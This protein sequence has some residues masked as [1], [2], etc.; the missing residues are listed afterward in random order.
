MAKMPT[1]FIPH[2]GG[3]CFFMDSEPADLWDSMEN[4]LKNCISDLPDRPKAILMISGHWEAD[5]PTIQ[6]GLAPPML[7]DYHGFPPHTY[8]L[9]FP[10][11]GAP[12]LATRVADLLQQN[13]IKTT[14]DAQ[15]GYDHGTFVPLLVALPNADIP[16]VQLS[17]YSH[18]DAK[19]HIELGQALEPLRDEGILI[20]GSGMS[21][22]NLPKLMANL[23]SS[24]PM[25]TPNEGGILFDNWLTDTCTNRQADLRTKLLI[26]W[27]SA[28]AARQAHPREEHLLPLHVAAGAAG[29]DLGKQV[30]AGD[31]FGTPIS[32]YQFG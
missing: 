29:A 27:A 23:R 7:F 32:A 22:H 20:I 18:M 26:D 12:D 14:T 24:N 1:L 9:K 25:S 21:Y 8:E 30:Y 16:V 5:I 2:G 6:T 31:L 11:A 19:A 13:G 17:I 3:P 10:A 15:H 28:P 4:Y